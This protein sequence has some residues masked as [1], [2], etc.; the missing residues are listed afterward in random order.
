[1]KTTKPSITQF[2]EKALQMA[3]DYTEHK[4]RHNYFQK[5][6]IKFAEEYHEHKVRNFIL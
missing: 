2:E 6:I 4:T 5:E 1:M 3:K